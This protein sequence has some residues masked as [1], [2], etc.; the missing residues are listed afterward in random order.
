M[1]QLVVV[2]EPVVVVAE[3]QRAVPCHTRLFPLLPPI[4]L[5]ARAHEELHLHL[6]ELPHAEYEL[7]CDDL[8]A[9][10][11][12]DLR[13]TERQLH[14]SGLL[15]V[16]K[17]DEY[18]LRRLGTQI[19]RRRTVGRR[20]HLRREHKVELS[21]LCPVA[22]ARYGAYDL[23]VED[24][25]AQL[26][27]VV[28]IQSLGE[29]LVHGVALGC[30]IGHARRG[31]TVLLLVEGLAEALARLLHLLGDLLVL[32]GEPILDQHV[33]TVTLL[34]IAVVDKRIVERADMSRSLPRAGVHEDRSVET[35]DVLVQLDHR[36]PPVALDI[37]LQLDAV[38]AVVVHGTQTVV[39][40]ARREYESVL[41][42]VS[43]EFLEKFVLCHRISFCYI[44]VQ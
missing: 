32:L 40:F 28:G 15:H 5:V 18:A 17:V 1:G 22:R 26:V 2:V 16:E 21:Y 43:H 3:A 41:L 19:Y 33:G 6:L 8:V 13:D 20:S 37:V 25:L 14:A 10:R 38:L 24:Y 23:A 27:K 42:A 4:H 30:D 12:A 11:L 35:H 44:P 31:G 34:R 39:Y 36:I 7:T 29:T 9:E